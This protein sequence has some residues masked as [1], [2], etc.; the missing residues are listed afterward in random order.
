[1]TK[2]VEIEVPDNVR[3]ITINF[4]ERYFKSGLESKAI[5]KKAY[6]EWLKTVEEIT[7][8]PDFTTQSKKTAQV[9][10]AF[11]K[12]YYPEFDKNS[13]NPLLDKFK[14]LDK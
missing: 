1:M 13:A 2:K 9:K 4:I 6:Q 11:I 12:K 10:K 3:A 5:T 14:A 7:N 8:N